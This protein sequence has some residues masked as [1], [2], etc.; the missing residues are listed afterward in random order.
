MSKKPIPR[1]EKQPL[2]TVTRTIRIGELTL[3]EEE[4]SAGTPAAAT[5]EAAIAGNVAYTPKALDTLERHV[6]AAQ[7]RRPG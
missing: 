2:C 7:A 5:I 6:K 4:W 1:K 3:S